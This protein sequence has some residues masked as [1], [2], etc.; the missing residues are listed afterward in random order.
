MKRRF[1]LIVNWTCWHVSNFAARID[2]EAVTEQTQRLYNE[3]VKKDYKNNHD[4]DIDDL[5]S[6]FPCSCENTHPL[7]SLSDEQWEAYS[8]GAGFENN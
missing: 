5:M 8:E 7:H 4:M 6:N 3:F 1:A 2:E